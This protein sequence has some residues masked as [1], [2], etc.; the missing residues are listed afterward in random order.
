[1]PCNHGQ[2]RCLQPA[3]PGLSSLLSGIH[4]L[5]LQK[6]GFAAFGAFGPC[7]QTAGCCCSG[8][9]CIGVQQV[10][11]KLCLEQRHALNSLEPIV[12][13]SRNTDKAAMMPM[14]HF[15]THCPVSIIC[16]CDA[17]ISNHD[18]LLALALE[19]RL[20]NCDSRQS[21]TV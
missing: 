21:Q 14:L 2:C 1:M 17:A 7:N 9:I 15:G 18:G 10:L 20:Q 3:Q 13:N 12:D 6:L 16:T 5:H 19:I 11:Q 4:L 8:S